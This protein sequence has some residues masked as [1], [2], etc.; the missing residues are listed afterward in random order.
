MAKTAADWSAPPK[1]PATHY[2]DSRIYTDPQIFTEE[3]E[4]WELPN[5]QLAA[6]VPI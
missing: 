3:L 5:L 2:V 1:L 6:A 4:A